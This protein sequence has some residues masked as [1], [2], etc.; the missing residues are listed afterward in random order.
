ME[1]T[2]N[3]ALHLSVRVSIDVRVPDTIFIPPISG[4]ASRNPIFYYI[5]ID[6]LGSV[7]KGGVFGTSCIKM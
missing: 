3:A 1:E 4:Y 7:N 6:M 2:L 5:R